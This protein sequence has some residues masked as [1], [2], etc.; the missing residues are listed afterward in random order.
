MGKLPNCFLDNIIFSIVFDIAM[1][2]FL[3]HFATVIIA[4]FRSIVEIHFF[5]DRDR[6]N[7]FSFQKKRYAFCGFYDRSLIYSILWT[8]SNYR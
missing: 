2:D 7:E 8:I 1:R 5:D 6:E 3:V 4:L